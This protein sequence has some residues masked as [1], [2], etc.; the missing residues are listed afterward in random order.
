MSS[1]SLRGGSPLGKCYKLGYIIEVQDPSR[2][3]ARILELLEQHGSL[4][5]K[6]EGE[7]IRVSIPRGSSRADLPAHAAPITSRLF[8]GV[9]K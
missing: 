4:V 5:L 2:R 1:F 7:G 3:A 6:K 9:M 8:G